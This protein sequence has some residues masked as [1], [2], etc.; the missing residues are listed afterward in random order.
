MRNGIVFEKLLT[1][2]GVQAC[3]VQ[4]TPASA[5]GSRHVPSDDEFELCVKCLRSCHAVIQCCYQHASLGQ[6]RYLRALRLAVDCQASCRAILAIHRIDKNIPDGYEACAE[7]CEECA[8]ECAK[9]SS[10]ATLSEC[11]KICGKLV[12]FCRSVT[13]QAMP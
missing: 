1:F 5:L 6:L 9:L 8:A 7:A 3:F 2:L 11:I 4:A 13:E 12:L 10:E